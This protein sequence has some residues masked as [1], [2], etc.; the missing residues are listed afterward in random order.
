MSREINSN[1][2]GFTVMELLIVIVI[3][4]IL[5]VVVL[6]SIQGLHSQARDTERRVDIEN[7][8]AKLEAHWVTNGSYPSRLEELGLLPGLNPEALFDPADHPIVVSSSESTNKPASGYS[9]QQPSEGQYLY[10]SYGCSPIS[11]PDDQA[12]TEAPAVVESQTCSHYVLYSWLEE[13]EIAD[14][15]VYEK[16]SLN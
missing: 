14:Q 1:S 2:R 4:G 12:E 9:Q 16:S 6:R 7:L 13:P 15:P 10:T 8:H 3:A 11:S 5:A